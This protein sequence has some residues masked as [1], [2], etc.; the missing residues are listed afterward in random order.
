M[1]RC[2]PF[3]LLL[4]RNDRSGLKAD[5]PKPGCVERI[6]DPLPTAFVERIADPLHTFPEKKQRIF[7]PLYKDSIAMGTVRA[8]QAAA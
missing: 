7:D 2:G 5:L 3:R 8:L 1:G 4:H 6:E